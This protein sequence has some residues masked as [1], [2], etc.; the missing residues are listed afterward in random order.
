M[1]QMGDHINAKNDRNVGVKNHYGLDFVFT[2]TLT[3]IMHQAK[4]FLQFTALK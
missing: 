4:N 2:P 3:L 1:A